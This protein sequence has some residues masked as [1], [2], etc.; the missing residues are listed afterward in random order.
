MPRCINYRESKFP[1]VSHGANAAGERAL[2]KLVPGWLSPRQEVL[3]FRQA[4]AAEGGA[5][6]VVVVLAAAKK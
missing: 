6:A 4:R 2:K 5:G 1:Q 3:A